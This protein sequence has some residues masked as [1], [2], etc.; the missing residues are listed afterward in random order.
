MVF[1]I[2]RFITFI[3]TV[4]NKFFFL[5]RDSGAM[6]HDINQCMGM[7]VFSPEKDFS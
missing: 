5:V 3:K 7:A 6:V 4:K 1:F 2:S